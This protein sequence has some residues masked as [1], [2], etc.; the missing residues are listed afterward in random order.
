MN[1]KP[2]FGDAS[3]GSGKLVI[4]HYLAPSPGPAVHINLFMG[5]SAFRN[6]DLRVPIAAQRIKNP[7]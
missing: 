4:F 5:S 2:L 6:I 3:L 7:T 1:G